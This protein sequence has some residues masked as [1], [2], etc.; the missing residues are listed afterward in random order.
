MDAD[1]SKLEHWISDNEKA[2]SKRPDL[3]NTPYVDKLEKELV[4]LKLFNNEISEQQAKLVTLTQSSDQIG[5]SLAP[6]GAAAL[7]DRINA[8]KGKISKL[9]ETV[10]GKINSISDA[11]MARQDFNAKMANFSN[12]MDQLRGQVAQVEEINAERVEPSL[13]TV[14]ALLQEHSEK[15]PVFSAIRDEVKDLTQRATPEESLIINDSYAALV[16]NYDDIEND[17]QRK[18]G[19]LEKWSELMGWKNE[20]EGHIS[21]IKHQLEKADKHEPPSLSKIVAEIDEVTK[22]VSHWKSQAMQIDDN[23][24]IHLRDMVT[25]KPLSAVQIVNDLGNKLD[26]LK[27]KSQGQMDVIHKMEERKSRFNNLENQLVTHLTQNQQ[28]LA[29]ILRN[30]PNFSNIDQI[31]SDLVALNEV[32]QKQASLKDKIHDEGVQLM[33]DDISSMPAIQESMLVLDKNWDGLQQEIVDR[34]QKYTIIS[35]G[36]KEYS[37]AKDRFGKELQKA[38]TIYQSVPSAPSGEQQL[39]QTAD[40][41]KKA[42]EQIKKSK[43]TLDEL[44]RKGHALL[45]LFDA[46]ENVIPN[47]IATEMET[48]HKDWQQLYDKISKNAHIYETEAVIW[49]QIEENKNE[50]I[51]W[52]SETNQSLLDAA[53]NTLEIEFGPIRLNKYTTELPSYIG[54]RDD[55]IEKITELTRM[56]N[57][58]PIPQLEQLKNELIQ[59]FV[60]V[61][62]NAQ[63]LQAVASTFDEQE[64]DLR[65]AIKASGEVVT[66]LREALIKC[67]D[68]SGDNAKIMQRLQDCKAL[69]D[70]LLDQGSDIDNLRIRVDEMK[71]NYPTFA[72]SIVP[73][74]LSNIQKRFDGVIQHANKIEGALLQFLKKFSNDKVGMLQRMITTQKDKIAWCAPESTSDKYNL[75]V[76]K[77]SLN[78]VQKG[79]AECDGRL[80]EVQKSL[81]MLS[82]V[83]TPDVALKRNLEKISKDLNTLRDQYDTTKHVLDLNVDLWTQYEQLTENVTSWLKDIESKVKTEANSQIEV[84]NVE[85]KVTDLENYAVQIKAYKP[86]IDELDGIAKALM[87]TNSEARVGQFVSH[88]TARYQAV[89][90]NVANQLE[91]VRDMKSTH[92]IYVKSAEECKD[93]IQDARMEFNELARMGSPGSGPTSEQLDLVKQFVKDLENGQILLNNAVDS[94]EYLYSGITPENRE[95]IRNEIRKLREDFDNVHDEGNSLLSQVE[96]VL[97]QKTSIEESYSQVKQ[98]LSES[99]AKFSQT[100]LYPTL[101]EKKAALQKF[102]SQ[103]QDNNLH[104][105]ALKQL[106]SKASSLS[107]EEAEQRVAHSIHE[108]DTLSKNLNERIAILDNQVA[109]HEAYDQILEKSHD[110][111]TALK[112]E[113][114]DIL[115][116]GTFEKDGAEEKLIVVENMIMQRPEGEKIFAAC[117]KQ[118]QTV[119]QQ[120]HPKGHPA[121]INVYESQKNSWDEFINLCEASMSKL[122]QL[123]SKW[124]EFENIIERLDAWLKQTENIVRDQSLKS[125]AEKKEEHLKKLNKINGEIASKAAEISNIVEQGHEIEGETD[126][127]LRVSRLNTRYQTLKNICKESIGRY[128]V[129][130]KEHKTFNNDYEVFKNE[131]LKSIKDLENNGEVIGDYAILQDRQN[132]IRGMSEKRINDSTMFEALI[133]R[134]E[135]LYTHTSPDGRE[136]IRQQLRLLR[137][138]WDNFTDDLNSSTQKLDQC[139]LQFG[140]FTAAQEQLTKWLKDVEKSMEI[141]TELKATLQEKRAQLQNHK[142]MHQEIISHNALVESVCDKAQ[143]LVDQTKDS[144][145]NIYLQSIRQL[146]ENIVS[147]SQDLLENLEGCAQ[148]HHDFNVDVANLKS[149]LNSE[150]EK[151]LEC[152]DTTGEK[153]DI[154]RKLNSLELL[155]SNKANGDKM[156]NELLDKYKIVKKST[157]PKGVEILNKEL[158]DLRT[159]YANH[160]NDINSTDDK[161]RTALQQWKDFEKNLDDLTKWCR[162]SEAIFRDQQLQS[163]IGQKTKQLSVFKEQRENILQKQKL[164]DEFMDEASSLLNNSEADRLKP[165]IS[166]LTNRH[167]LLQVLSKE[168][169]NRWQTMVSLMEFNRFG[170]P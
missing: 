158:D 69:K 9:S 30:T 117:H 88:L 54:I 169:V 100:E 123:C 85:S 129:Y 24:V 161:L 64:K 50:L 27:L 2:I 48:S 142:L 99:K 160:Y 39:L 59:Q 14:H 170:W 164:I 34:I 3:T 43:G 45:K 20:T 41:S 4:K 103:L 28:K 25:R 18:K 35:Q 61:N 47:E 167:Q 58:V 31:I 79:I 32:M 13:Q 49:N 76:K 125:T 11:I 133:D 70:Q 143:H 154:N 101:A 63:Q 16:S 119:L 10:R 78:D 145:L 144:S 5:L 159:S 66:K 112:A 93:W 51:P 149:W 124:D 21:H 151:L 71:S 56:N 33:K 46:I 121:L 8:M 42:L 152:D 111:L 65:K 137:T 104:K 40:K 108:Y 153:S 60:D 94:G 73:K 146:F 134:G 131:L 122:K 140:E 139:L 127:N 136:I 29:E 38:L 72:E 120:T 147:K 86:T 19:S 106:Q 22:G 156:L 83:D 126:L 97:L 37:D 81:D 68:M 87:A 162:S 12:W 168:V 74:E 91:R 102:K 141:H 82:V 95:K 55:I 89:S 1:A 163:T 80:A 116:E 130:T 62:T 107:D 109:N 98:W 96:S 7:K 26:A 110:W 157:S 52:L 15:K 114:T 6:D 113:A 77:S 75:E 165:L 138:S 118:L 155:K 128:E 105:S 166:Q 57:G 132:K 90:R 67:D 44:E 23:P 17:L 92:D 84:N 53:E 115:N 135:K 150:M 148:A 36:L